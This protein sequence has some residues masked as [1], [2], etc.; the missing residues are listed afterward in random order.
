MGIMS[1]IHIASLIK[2]FKML[3]KCSDGILQLNFVLSSIT[4][5][6]LLV[7][8]II[9]NLRIRMEENIRFK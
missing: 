9:C 4:Y 6:T 3:Q 5:K 1:I 8:F 2:A 7:I